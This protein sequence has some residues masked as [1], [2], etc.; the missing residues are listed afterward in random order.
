MEVPYPPEADPEVIAEAVV[1]HPKGWRR[2]LRLWPI[3]VI[4]AAVGLAFATGL[5]RYLSP[6][7]LQEKRAMLLDYVGAHPVLGVLIYMGA[8]AVLVAFSLPGAL[9]MTLTG[10]F[11]FGVWLGTAWAAIGMTVGAVAMFLAARS[12]L[13]DFL[14]SHTPAGRMMKRVE[15]GVRANAFVYL[16][17]LRLIPAVPFW[18]CNIASGLV[19]IPIR[20]YIAA[21]F[22]GVI[23][24]TL[25]YASVGAGLGHVF[26]RGDTLSLRLI[27]DPEILLPLIGLGALACLPLVYHAWRIRRDRLGRPQAED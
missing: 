2:F 14:K 16:L 22:L 19:A 5:N 25:I 7:L 18:L 13:G 17:V 10:G 23:P 3:V 1:P 8:Y 20:T 24:S 12:S 6:D 11:L 9:L 26:D 4:L 21:T 27:L 15:T